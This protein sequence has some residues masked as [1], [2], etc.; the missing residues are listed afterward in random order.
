MVFLQ[1]IIWHY[2]LHLVAKALF[3]ATPRNFILF[4][5]RKRQNTFYITPHFGD[6]ANNFFDGISCQKLF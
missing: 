4:C 1:N 5:C 3:C 6:N 2:K